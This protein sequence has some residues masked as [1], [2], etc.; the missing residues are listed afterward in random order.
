METNGVIFVYNPQA[1]E[2]LPELELLFDYFIIQNGLNNLDCMVLLNQRNND[3]DE[4][5]RILRK[6]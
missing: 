6:L 4:S 1:P 2:Q 5:R 3:L